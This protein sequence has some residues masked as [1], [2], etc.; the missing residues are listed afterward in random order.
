MLPK[1]KKI[2]D[3]NIIIKPKIT[4]ARLELI[5]TYRFTKSENHLS[6]LLSDLLTRV[7]KDI[8]K[9]ESNRHN[10]LDLSKKNNFI[11]RY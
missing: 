1:L 7:H 10:Y 11:N 4:A 8:P 3:Y 5:K 6:L 2:K 9:I